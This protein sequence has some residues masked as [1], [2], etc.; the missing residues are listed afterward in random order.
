MAQFDFYQAPRS[1]GYLLD[2]QADLLDALDTR[3]VVPL[4]PI[5]VFPKRAHSLN[6]EF[7]ID[8]KRYVMVPE[9]VG[10]ISRIELNQP[11]GSLENQRNIIIRAIDVLLAGA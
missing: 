1:Q 8:G 6:P 5:K 11:T 2:I 4:L 7:D 9:F 10:A 3:V